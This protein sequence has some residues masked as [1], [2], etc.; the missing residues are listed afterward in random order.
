[1]RVLPFILFLS[2]HLS[3]LA[4]APSG[5]WTHYFT[6]KWIHYYHT[7][8]IDHRGLETE[9]FIVCMKSI[10]RLSNFDILI[11]N[12]RMPF[13]EYYFDQWK[14]KLFFRKEKSALMDEYL[15]ITTAFKEVTF[16]K[17]SKILKKRTYSQ[18][19]KIV[20]QFP[21]ERIAFQKS[22][23]LQD[24][25]MIKMINDENLKLPREPSSLNK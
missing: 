7:L 11:I 14:M 1:M 25:W 13:S 24:P 18:N 17:Q 3:S 8:L 19:D 6:G 10:C 4:A 23:Y 20:V 12:K 22:N 2:I 9:V 15:R 16:F 21:R 5:E